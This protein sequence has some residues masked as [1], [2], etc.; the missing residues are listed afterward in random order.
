MPKPI[1]QCLE[2]TLKD[3]TE[4]ELRKFKANLHEFPVKD[5]YDNIPR[6]RLQKADAL[7]LSDLLFA[8]YIDYAVEVTAAVLRRCQCKPQAEKLVALSGIGNQPSS[9]PQQHFIDQFREQLIQRTATVEQVLD[10]LHGS[11]LNE[12]QYQKICSQETNQAKM[13]E[14]Y[15]LVPGWNHL[16][17]DQL[18]NALKAINPYLIN[19]LEATRKMGN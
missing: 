5:G 18:Y 11:I 4:D 2:E 13:R 3:L 8:Y 16:C 19:D 6:G 17:K 15:K 1:R 14:L 10:K 12:E 9:S 7:D